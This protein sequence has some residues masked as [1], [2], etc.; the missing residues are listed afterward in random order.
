M[1]KKNTQNETV[2]VTRQI[3]QK[4]Q[5]ENSESVEN[6]TIEVHDFVTEAARV[7][8]ERGVTMSLG[9]W[10]SVRIG[11]KISLPC[12]KEEIGPAFYRARDWVDARLGEEID[13]V[14]NMAGL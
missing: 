5:E 6:D 12:Y 11:V 3:K 14:K 4:N 8:F 10:Q 7:E 13:A 9:N 2:T 1:A